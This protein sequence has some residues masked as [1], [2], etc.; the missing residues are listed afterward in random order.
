M[1]DGRPR[2]FL[3]STVKDLAD[4]RSAL[5]Y[6]LEEYGFVVFASEWP[7]FPHLLDRETVAAALGPIEQSDYYIAVLGMRA[8]SIVKGTNI[9]ATRTEFRRARELHRVAGRPQM[10]HLVRTDVMAARRLGKP[11]GIDADEWTAITAFLEEVETP[12]QPGDPNWVRAFG[13]FRDVADTLRATLRLTG[14]LVRR[15][16]EANL[17]WELTENAKELVF[18]LGDR[19]VPKAY[20]LPKI[21]PSGTGLTDTVR[22]EPGDAVRIFL[23]RLS[24]PRTATIS[25]AALDEA[26]NSGQFLDY[27][28]STSSF[29]IGP[30]QRCL[31][32]L[33]QQM[34]RLDSL[35]ET[36]SGNATVQADFAM[37]AEGGRTKRSVHVTGF[38]LAFLHAAQASELNLL[39][40]AS[41][42]YRY[43]SGADALVKVPD[44]LRSQLTDEE[45]SRVASEEV[46]AAEAAQWLRDS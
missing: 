46:T 9:S 45:E 25:R 26:I 24:L 15:A 22:V 33:R 23:F 34:L 12:E 43:V 36:I 40:L 41:A 37:L 5:K 1:L 29:T 2:V 4:L 20:H 8:G 16:L 6:W 14:P 7:D 28:A 44:L 13:S 38:T 10:L 19:V 17:K 27:D 3:S 35:A 39:S 42:I 21:Q 32:D 30:L 11:A 18:R 31:L